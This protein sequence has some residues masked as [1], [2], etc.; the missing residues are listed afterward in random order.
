MLNPSTDPDF[1]GKIDP[2]NNARPFGNARDAL[3]ENDP[4]A[5]PLLAKKFNDDWGFDAALAAEAQFTPSGEPDSAESSQRLAGL[6]ALFDVSGTVAEIASGNNKLGARVYVIERDRTFIIENGTANGADKIS[7]GPGRVGV[8]D[9]GTGYIDPKWFGAETVGNGPNITRLFE[10]CNQNGRGVSSDSL[11]VNQTLPV[12]DMDIGNLIF[13]S[14]GFNVGSWTK[15]LSIKISSLSGP[16]TA[17]TYFGIFFPPA[18]QYN[19]S[20]ELGTVINTDVTLATQVPLLDRIFYFEEFNGLD[21][22]VD[23]AENIDRLLR[24]DKCKRVNIISGSVKNYLTAFW[25]ETEDFEFSGA[26][27]VNTADFNNLV[28]DSAI[29]LNGRD[30]IL[31]GGSVRNVIKSANSTKAA[32]RGFYLQLNG[33]DN[34]VSAIIEDKE[35]KT[36]GKIEGT[37]TMSANIIGCSVAH[38]LTGTFPLT[39]YDA[40]GV[41]FI[42]VNCTTPVLV[43]PFQFYNVLFLEF[44]GCQ[45]FA[46]LSVLLGSLVLNKTLGQTNIGR[47]SNLT[48]DYIINFANNFQSDD[49]IITDSTLY[50]KGGTNFGLC[51]NNSSANPTNITAVNTTIR[52]D[53]L[54]ALNTQNI[55]LTLD[56]VKILCNDIS[57]AFIVSP[58]IFATE[59]FANTTVSSSALLGVSCNFEGNFRRTLQGGNTLDSLFDSF[60][61]SSIAGSIAMPLRNYICE[62]YDANS[63]FM[64][65][66][67]GTTVT[68]IIGTRA[69]KVTTDTT[70]KTLTVGSSVKVSITS[71]P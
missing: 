19:I 1:T 55:T 66:V 61:V 25:I 59:V 24:T 41:S 37:N 56:R 18:S 8:V 42:D 13:T 39:A 14:G 50:L 34:N 47:D 35:I 46:P 67:V 63:Y 2:P 6:H 27:G 20:I 33:T 64:F 57:S 65:S 22:K 52:A 23:R 45:I 31:G 43:A 16:S 4:N 7:A 10:Y 58:N 51:I 62:G 21:F 54:T 38:E 70:A 71:I 32:E 29:P 36:V 3:V 44:Q 68:D 28:I 17:S 60:V 12:C 15:D 49:I 11:T 26:N 69:G 48:L 40:N 9:Y 30:F 5:T 53:T